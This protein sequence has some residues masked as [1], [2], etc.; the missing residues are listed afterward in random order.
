MK[1]EDSTAHTA[2]CFRGE[3]ASCSCACPFHLDVRALLDKVSRSRWQAAYKALCSATVF[4][5]IV[6]AL[7]DEPCRERCQRTSL[8]DEAISMRDIEAA[9]LRFARDRKPESYV[10]P[11]KGKSVA[12]V[13]AGVA[14]LSLAL[15]LAQKRFQVTVFEKGDGW[16]GSLRSHP[17]FADF[18]A[19]IALQFSAVEAEFLFDA[20]VARLDELAD[21][22]AVYI[23]TGAGGESFGLGEICDPLLFTTSEP[24]VFMGGAICGADV[25]ESIAQGVEASMVIEAFLQTGRATRSPGAVRQGFLRPHPRTR[26]RGPSSA[27]GSLQCRGLHGRRGQSRGQALPPVRLRLLPHRLRDVEALSKGPP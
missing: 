2:R 26:R 6:S 22:D 15:N 4:P 13:G 9:C 10:I 8:G 23:A 27:R 5:A 21:F 24:K 16:G 3:P 17:D 1:L 20:E 18:D 11:P 12:V 14:G 19:D 25:M 7:C